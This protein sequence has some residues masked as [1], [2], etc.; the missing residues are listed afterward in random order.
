M[1]S[2]VEHL[3]RTTRDKNYNWKAVYLCECG[4]EFECYE[5][6]VRRGRTTSCGCLRS[7]WAKAQFTTHGMYATPSYASWHHMKARCNN[8]NHEFYHRYG[9]R[10]ITYDPKWE[11]FEGFYEDMGEKPGK[12]WDID[13]ID[14]D[15]NYCKENCQWLTRSENAKKR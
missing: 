2:S 3:Y 9:G 1:T 12:G 6:N 10:G 11:T 8:K 5:D 15:G 13:R 14:N 4:E 7:A